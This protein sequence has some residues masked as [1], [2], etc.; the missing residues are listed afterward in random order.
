[1]KGFLIL[2]LVLQ[3]ALIGTFVALD[4]ILFFIFWIRDQ[5]PRWFITSL[6]TITLFITTVLAEKIMTQTSSE[7]IVFHLYKESLVVNRSGEKG[8]V[9]ENQ[10]GESFRQES[11]LKNYQRQHLSLDLESSK[12]MKN[13]FTIGDKRVL[14]V[15]HDNIKSDYGFEPD[16]L[17]LMNSPKINLNRLLLKIRPNII[18]ADGSN[19]F[20]Y[21]LLWRRTAEKSK[22][23]FFDTAKNGAFTLANPS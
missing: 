9:F 11:A 7:L 18:V 8:S 17:I 1:M 2:M 19:Y 20:T 12:K 23:T 22:I 21:K 13:F 14:I 16:I 4:M 10:K 15:D 6:I 3:T 5:I